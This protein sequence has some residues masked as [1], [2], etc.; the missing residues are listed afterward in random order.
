MLNFYGYNGK[1]RFSFS[2]DS[3]D[4]NTYTLPQSVLE[5]NPNITVCCDTFD[6]AAGEEGYYLIPGNVNML[7][8]ALIP[9]KERED[10]EHVCNKTLFSL[11]G[12]KNAAGA[13]VVLLERNYP[14]ILKAQVKDGRYR[15][16]V[17]YRLENQPLDG[18]LG[19]TV[20]PMPADSDYNDWANAI[21][22]YWIEKGEVTPLKDKC[23][24]RPELEYA[25]K[26][27]LIRIRMGWK[28][29][30]SPVLSQ[31]EETEP[32]M[33]VACTFARV[34]DIAD[35]MHR[36]GIPG[37]EIS[38]VGFNQKGH[39]GR[40]PQIFPVEEALGGE[41]ELRK[42]IEHCQSL[43]YAVTCH[44]NT[45]DH[46]EIA[47]T[48]D[49]EDLAY[50]KDGGTFTS[51][52][53]GGGHSYRACPVT[54][55][56]YA[57]KDLPRVAKLGFRGLHYIDVL[58]IVPP[59]I[60]FHEKHPCSYKQ[61]IEYMKHIMRLSTDLLG[62][63]SSEGCM[64][65]SLSDLDFSLY[66]WQKDYFV[67]PEGMAEEY[68]PLSELLCHGILLYNPCPK[69]I[70]HTIKE[71]DIVVMQA[72]Y[73]GRPTFYFYS[74]FRTDWAM[75][76]KDDLLCDTEE[77]L[78]E[79]VAAIKRSCD[80]YAPVADRQFH[81]MTGYHN[82]GNGVRVITYDDGWKTIANISDEPIDVEGTVVPAHD[83]IT[84]SPT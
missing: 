51:G 27:P 49:F 18:G 31:T 20:L 80:S 78:R 14:C 56:R 50:G 69:T 24:R 35:E 77:Q 61:S 6:A 29:V 41:E 62:G 58:S 30:P 66:N 36:Q 4:P 53:W 65:F 43:G 81:Y 19:L 13:F 64:D 23:A 28:P 67:K 17:E 46:Y 82:Y 84:I 55:Y 3:Q 76:G 75:T 83:Y 33:K 45:C 16:C 52:T 54:Q 34:R 79:S 9:F 63:F 10:G 68:I 48:F 2:A 74:N 39:D 22:N 11:F 72:L 15:V 26:H 44:T 57:E 1:E 47:D 37:A 40:W 59:D 38:L 71:P 21:R 12:V 32:E 60:C 42:T 8:S 73:G 7:G 70:N 25:R 5:E